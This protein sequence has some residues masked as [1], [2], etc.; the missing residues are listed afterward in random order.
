M[1]IEI[2]DAGPTI[3]NVYNIYSV[4]HDKK[5]LMGRR[6]DYGFHTE[7]IFL[8]AKNRPMREGALAGRIT[9][10]EVKDLY[11]TNFS[12]PSPSPNPSPNPAPSP[13]PSLLT[14]PNI[15]PIASPSPTRSEIPRP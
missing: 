10:E 14:T 3:M 11:E 4:G 1:T 15:S 5:L 7:P 8:V 13:I 12:L 9:W 6:K 2:K